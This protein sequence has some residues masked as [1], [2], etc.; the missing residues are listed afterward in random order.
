MQVYILVFKMNEPRLCKPFGLTALLTL[1]LLN[2][3]TPALAQHNLKLLFDAYFKAR[4]Q[5]TLSETG[6]DYSE[7]KYW[8]EQYFFYKNQID[9]RLSEMI[10][11]ARTDPRNNCMNTLSA[12]D[13]Y[14]KVYT[15]PTPSAEGVGGWEEAAENFNRLQSYCSRFDIIY[16]PF[17]KMR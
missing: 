10:A 2:L 12:L 9:K 16:S 5:L 17:Q 8:T 7:I 14:Q 13:E 6:S 1:F 15:T 11:N 3:P 4:V